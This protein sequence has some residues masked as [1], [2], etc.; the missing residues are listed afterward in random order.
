MTTI[1]QRR[2][3]YCFALQAIVVEAR[4]TIGRRSPITRM[5]EQGADEGET[6]S[7]TASLSQREAVGLIGG[8]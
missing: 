1:G 3:H 7:P 8:V 5:D 2:E 4:S 6:S